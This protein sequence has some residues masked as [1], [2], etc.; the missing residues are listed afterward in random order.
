MV[1]CLTRKELHKLAASVMGGDIVWAELDRLE[2]A[3]VA[4]TD[5]DDYNWQYDVY[6]SARLTAIVRL[7]LE[8]PWPND[9][10]NGWGVRGKRAQITS[11]IKENAD[12]LQVLKED[13][14]PFRAQD[15]VEVKGLAAIE[16]IYGLG[17]KFGLHRGFNSEYEEIA[18]QTGNGVKGVKMTPK[19]IALLE[20]EKP[21]WL[22]IACDDDEFGLAKPAREWMTSDPTKPEEMIANIIYK[23]LEGFIEGFRNTL[24]AEKLQVEEA[25]RAKEARRVRAEEKRRVNNAWD[26]L[27]TDR[28]EVSQGETK[29]NSSNR[30]GKVRPAAP[31]LSNLHSQVSRMEEDI[32]VAPDKSPELLG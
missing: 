10:G 27:L 14:L 2:R 17:R 11:L 7:I 28:S 19:F 8:I 23:R 32:L 15:E 3:G 18:Y 20:K 9:K 26:G 6:P 21:T 30:V 13:F 16:I 31:S 1:D 29:R 22:E 24:R 4:L 12:F 25:Q 5:K